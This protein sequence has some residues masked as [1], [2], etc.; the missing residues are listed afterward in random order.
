MLG[1]GATLAQL[2]GGRINAR[3]AE[4]C[5][6]L[7]ACEKRPICVIL[8]SKRALTESST[9]KLDL[10]YANTTHQRRTTRLPRRLRLLSRREGGAECCG[11]VD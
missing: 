6:A 8:A 5:R 7:T 4:F 11:F 1:R 10:H 9:G 3:M 2:R